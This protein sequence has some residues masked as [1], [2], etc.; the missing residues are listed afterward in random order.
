MTRP[1]YFDHAATTPLDPRV[2]AAMQPYLETHFGN[3]A[4]VHRY[5][6]EAHAA[7]ETARQTV[8]R[9]LGCAPDEVVFT[10][11][12]TESNNAAIKGVMAAQKARGRGHLVVSAVEH[13]SV[14]EPA[15]QATRLLG[16][17]LTVLP[18]D[19]YGQV[20]P[21][22]VRRAL[23]P[24]TGLVSVMAA[25]NEVGTLQ[26]I[27]AIAR[28]CQEAGVPFH[29]DAVQT[30]PYIP[31]R[32]DT[33]PITLL[34]LSAHKM[35]GPKGVGVLVVRRGTPFEPLLAGGGQE[36]NRRSGT[37]NVPGIVGLAEALRL[38][39]EERAG[40]IA[41]VQALRDR[42]LRGALAVPGVR[43]TGHPEERLP[44]HVS[45]VV[46]AAPAQILLPLLDVAGFACSS[47]SACKVGKPEPSHVL[48]AM[49][50]TSQEALTALRITLGKDNTLDEVEAFL[51][52]FPEVVERARAVT[53]SM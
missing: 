21:D 39:H 50:Y 9:L 51:Q 30:A 13:P 2:F 4:S 3:P 24:D 32:L 22:D 46:D 52:V 47:G 26:P 33:L 12:G 45:F 38:A 15:R 20:D 34:S 28:I 42:L 53:I 5:G 29:V 19:R 7:V 48:L 44:H 14:L 36:N 18:V 17:E 10:S 27:E 23:R 31:M 43:L 37:L 6:Q 49:G 41:H 1:V 16:L 40:R 8:A 25:N 11:G 35:Y